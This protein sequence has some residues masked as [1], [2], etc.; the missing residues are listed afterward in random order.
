MIY[1]RQKKPCIET[2]GA[3]RWGDGAKEEFKSSGMGHMARCCKAAP[4]LWR[5]GPNAGMAQNLSGFFPKLANS[6]S[7]KSG[8][9]KGAFTGKAQFIACRSTE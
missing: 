3:P 7:G 8:W 6:S 5:I 2:A 9:G 1:I 4:T